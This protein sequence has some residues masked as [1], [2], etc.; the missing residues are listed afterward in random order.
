MML[1]GSLSASSAGRLV[2]DRVVAGSNV[3]RTP[4]RDPIVDEDVAEVATALVD[5]CMTGVQRVIEEHGAENDVERDFKAV[6][7]VVQESI[8][9]GKPVALRTI[10]RRLRHLRTKVLDEHLARGMA[11]QLW[12]YGDARPPEERK[13]GG[14]KRVV[15]A[16][17][18][19]GVEV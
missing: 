15:V 19:D 18:K 4:D 8:A 17:W 10:S 7:R 12:L 14:H 6:V 2:S 11:E 13:A 9:G 5:L 1:T 3:L 16:P